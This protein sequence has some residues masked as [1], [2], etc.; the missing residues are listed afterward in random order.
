MKLYSQV[1]IAAF[2]KKMYAVYSLGSQGSL[3][4]FLNVLSVCTLNWKTRTTNN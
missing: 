4:T 2:I 3:D 1:I